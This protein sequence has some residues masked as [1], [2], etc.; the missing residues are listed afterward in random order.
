MGTKESIARYYPF[1]FAPKFGEGSHKE[2]LHREG[3]ASQAAWDLVKQIY[4]LKNSDKA[5]FCTTSKKTRKIF[6]HSDTSMNTMSKK[7]LNPE[8]LETSRKSKT[9]SLVFT[10]NGEVHTHEGAQV[11][12]TILVMVSLVVSVEMRDVHKMSTQ[13]RHSFLG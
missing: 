12:S 7:E 5:M 6:V 9:S 11:S 3:C 4:K 1:F 13:V 10:A 2:T 8:E